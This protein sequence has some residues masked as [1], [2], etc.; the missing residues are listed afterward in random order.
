MLR[1]D[2]RGETWRKL[3]GGLP[4]ANQYMISGVDINP[5][6]PD[7]VFVT[8]TDGS[9]YETDDAGAT[10]RQILSGIDRLFGV[11]VVPQ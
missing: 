11:R 1:S 9:L 6:D 7:M 10:W 4:S 3:G 2:D 8:F 5:H